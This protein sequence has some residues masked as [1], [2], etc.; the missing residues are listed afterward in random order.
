MSSKV[1]FQDV[2][3]P[4]TNVFFGNADPVKASLAYEIRMCLH[5]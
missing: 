5:G 1:H 4:A 2:R 3:M